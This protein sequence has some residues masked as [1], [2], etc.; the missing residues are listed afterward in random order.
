MAIGLKIDQ[1]V[2][3]LKYNFNMSLIKKYSNEI[4][5]SIGLTIA[6]FITRLVNLMVVP[7]FTDEAIYTRWSQ[8]AR[9]DGAWRFISLTDG[10]QPSFVWLDM[11]F[12]RFFSD[13]LMAGRIVSV[14]SGFFGMVGIFFLASEIFKNK[15]LGFIASALYIIYPFSLVYDKMALY[16]SLVATLS[17][18]SLYLIVLLVRRVRLDVALILGMVLGFGALTKAN[19]FLSIYLMPFA[20]LL[21]KFRQKDK[22]R[23]LLKL[24]S[25]AALSAVMAYGFYMVLRLS[26]FFHI[27]D[28]KT[29][30]FI[31]TF[32]EWLDHPFDF[33]FGNFNGLV[34]WFLAYFTIPAFIGSILAF[35]LGGKKFWQ[36]KLL[37]L[38]WFLLPFL[39]LAVFGRILYPRF[40]LFMTLPLIVLLAFSINYVWENAKTNIAKYGLIVTAIAMMLVSDFYVLTD[41]ARAPIAKP[42]TDQFMNSWPAGGGVREI[43]SFF[44]EK[45]KNQKIYV[46][47]EGTFGSLATYTVEIYLGDNKNVDKRGIY[48]L[49][50][51]IPADLVERASKMPVYLVINDSQKPPANWPLKLIARYQKGIGDYYMGLYEVTPNH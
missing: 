23:N 30:L 16:D 12:M 13:P 48:P 2:I 6:Y 28:E 29:H 36:E 38:F 39:A 4:F 21:F 3:I 46:A 49:P 26:P 37:L 22:V 10:K 40:I 42:D 44:S 17:I 5:V 43:V 9:F 35:F 33:L 8:I 41:L 34:N 11:I 51:K 45:S 31:Y 24:I 14:V 1:L 15:K 25:L 7:M 19:A 18:W 50:E 32:R 27:I 20:L 47:T